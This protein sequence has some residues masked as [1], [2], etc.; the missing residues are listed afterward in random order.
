MTRTRRWGI[1]LPNTRERLVQRAYFV[2]AKGG[3]VHVG[4]VY[5]YCGGYRIARI[6]VHPKRYVG[7]ASWRKVR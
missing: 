5:G 3:Q 4:E 1:V 6:G 7:V 2:R